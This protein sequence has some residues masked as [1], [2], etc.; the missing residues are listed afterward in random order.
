M[1]E[2]N[3]CVP[4][5]FRF[6]PT[7]EELVG[8]YLMRKVTSQKI[9]LEIIRDV[10]LYRIEPWDL[11]ATHGE[12]LNC[13]RE[14]QKKQI[15]LDQYTEIPQLDSPSLSNGFDGMMNSISE[16][17]SSQRIDWKFLDSL[18]SSNSD[19]LGS[20]SAQVFPLD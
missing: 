8:Y 9:D 15:F 17:Q 1:E 12:S 4:P 14:L 11:Q 20:S 13:T 5:G 3:C 2:E 7:E 10:D 19:E 16:E 18:I 6:H